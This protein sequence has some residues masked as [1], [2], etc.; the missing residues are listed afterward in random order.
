MLSK[1]EV[2]VWQLPAQIALGCEKEISFSEMMPFA[3]YLGGGFP[4][5]VP[6]KDTKQGVRA[7]G[8]AYKEGA[9][10]IEA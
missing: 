10:E 7:G 9:S 2:S 5:G 6:C 1:N 8:H 3:W 4:L